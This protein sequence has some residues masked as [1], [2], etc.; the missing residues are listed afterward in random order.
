MGL[1]SGDWFRNLM[2][3]SGTGYGTGEPDEVPR[4]R[5]LGPILRHLLYI[6]RL[7]VLIWHGIGM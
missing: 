5:E 7:H 4:L 2:W 6:F 1:N 3:W